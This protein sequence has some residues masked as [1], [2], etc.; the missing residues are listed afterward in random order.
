[1][2]PA[3]V[4]FGGGTGT[5]ASEAAAVQGGP[6]GDWR[7]NPRG[8][9]RHPT[10]TPRSFTTGVRRSLGRRR[11]LVV[12]TWAV[13]VQ[14]AHGRIPANSA[15]LRRRKGLL[16]PQGPGTSRCGRPVEGASFGAAAPSLQGMR[17]TH[18]GCSYGRAD[19]GGGPE[20]L[21]RA[22]ATQCTQSAEKTPATFIAA[23][24]GARA[25][26]ADDRC[27][28]LPAGQMQGRGVW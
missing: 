9:A 7:A 4:Y 2:S 27:H 1:M 20:L 18:P 13:F 14:G 23:R 17:S 15:F 3:R 8:A 6:Q 12:S 19:P 16:H 21:E 5:A 10:R 26:D 11:P 22:R 24:R 25:G 28:G